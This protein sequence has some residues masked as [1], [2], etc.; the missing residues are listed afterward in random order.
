MDAFGS[1]IERF[2]AQGAPIDWVALE[3]VI[4]SLNPLALAVNAPHPAS[5]RLLIDFLLSKEGQ[6]VGRTVAKL[7]ARADVEAPYPRLT[8]GLKLYPVPN[9]VAERSYDYQ[10]AADK[11]QRVDPDQQDGAWFLLGCVER[12]VNSFFACWRGNA[13]C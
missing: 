7:P 13:G 9:A 4:V 11:R 5:A 8:R 3:P 10:A 6:E 2:K 1:T 12:P